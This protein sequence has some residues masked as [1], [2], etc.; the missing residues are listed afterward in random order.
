MPADDTQVLV[1]DITQRLPGV[2][3]VSVTPKTIGDDHA[4]LVSFQHSGMIFKAMFD[5]HPR[6]SEVVWHFRRVPWMPAGS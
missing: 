1:D 2:S 3:D 5:H 4:W 6:M